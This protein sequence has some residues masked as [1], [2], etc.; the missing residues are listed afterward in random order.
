[1]SALLKLWRAFLAL[2]YLLLVL[3]WLV[4]SAVAGFVVVVLWALG[5]FPQ[6]TTTFEV[7]PKSLEDWDKLVGQD[8]R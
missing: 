7:T 1:M 3:V 2:L 4:G 6:E 8:G 5:G